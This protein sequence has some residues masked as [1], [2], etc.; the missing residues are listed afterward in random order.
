MS[1]WDDIVSFFE[2]PPGDPGRIRQIA[3]TIDAIRSEYDGHANSLDSAVNTLTA[4]WSGDSAN[5]FRNTWYDGSGQKS[6]SQTLHDVSAALGTFSRNL[7]DYADKL[8]HAQNEHWIAIGVLVALTVVNVAQLG[9]D[10]ATDAAEVG[11][12]AAVEVGASMLLPTIGTAMIEGALVGFSADVI[13]QLGA[14]LLDHLDPNFNQTGDN[15]VQLFNAQEAAVSTVSGALSFG[16]AKGAGAGLQSLGS[17]LFSNLLENPLTRTFTVG[18]IAGA[19][20]ATGQLITTGHIDWGSVAVTAGIA[21]ASSNLIFG[22]GSAAPEAMPTV[23]RA[24]SF[25]ELSAVMGETRLDGFLG[26][27]QQIKTAHPELAGIPDE[28]LAALR[29]YTA[30]D[31]TPPD[32]S[33]LN[34]ALRS[35]DP[36]QIDPLRPYIENVHGALQA[37]PDHT[38]VVFRGTN[39]PPAAIANYEHALATGQPITEPTFFSTSMDPAVTQQAPFQGNATYVIES[40]HGKDVSA[41]A[42][43]PEREVLFPAGTQ[44]E[45]LAVDQPTSGHYEIVLEEAS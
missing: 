22:R 29:G 13:S 1:L 16:F 27:V 35:G 3:S 40:V 32:Y 14:D 17:P 12:V 42:V 23:P 28:Q 7:R 18:A 36:A 39:L 44:F 31:V 45:V 15:S 33:R 25:P 43:Y 8:E 37:M 30:H 9:M 24:T 10:P 4:S 21:G 41:V 34:S 2:G 19:S 26:D 11:T 5:Q 6:P 20:D 38:G